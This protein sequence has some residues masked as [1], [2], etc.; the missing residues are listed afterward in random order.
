MG[1]SRIVK[2][3]I[4]AMSEAIDLTTVD[5]RWSIG[6][7]IDPV[8]RIVSAR[9]PAREHIFLFILGEMSDALSKNRR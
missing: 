9:V 1:R 8:G 3:I 4:V 6:A 7:R 5:K 2:A